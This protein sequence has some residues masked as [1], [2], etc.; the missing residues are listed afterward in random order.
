MFV[1]N[2]FLEK[3]SLYTRSI[4]VLSISVLQCCF[5]VTN[6][7]LSSLRLLRH[8]LQTYVEVLQTD[9]SGSDF[10]A[11]HPMME[12]PSVRQRKWKGGKQNNAAT[13]K[14]SWQALSCFQ[15]S[16]RDRGALQTRVSGS[17]GY[18]CYC[19]TWAAMPDG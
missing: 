5:N 4:W 6:T 17:G 14:Q 1:N 16:C 9:S 11:S 3:M 15:D 13:R 7:K 19:V 18:L 8:N 2:P 12:F 10:Q